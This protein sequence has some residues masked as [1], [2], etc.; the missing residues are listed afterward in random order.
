MNLNL[1]NTTRLSNGDT[2]NR[3]LKALYDN[4]P[5]RSL[6][7]L[8]NTKLFYSNEG[9]YLDWFNLCYEHID[10]YA[11]LT[12]MS[13]SQLLF[14]EEKLVPDYTQLD[15]IVVPMIE[16]MSFAECRWAE[17][18]IYRY[19]PAFSWLPSLGT[20]P[21]ERFN[22]YLS[23]R[24]PPHAKR[25]RADNFLRPGYD[26]PDVTQ[27]ILRVRRMSSDGRYPTDFLPKLAVASGVSLHW[28]M[29]LREPLYFH[30][31]DQEFLY[32]LFT[33][34]PLSKQKL[35]AEILKQNFEHRE[36]CYEPD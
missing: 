21:T 29:G 7:S 26:T 31:P 28:I 32:D 3:I 23:S 1:Y 16:K 12:N 10:D 15:E 9:Q 36:G 34:L 6:M 22:A 25:E 33:I 17:D 11:Q 4:L 5:L 24:I 18:L 20:N 30:T 14:G 8:R 35:I 19:H 27:E 13:L 2:A